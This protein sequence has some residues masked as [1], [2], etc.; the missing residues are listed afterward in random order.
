MRVNT[1]KA[2]ITV[3]DNNDK[4]Q[5]ITT[6]PVLE[7][8]K[9]VT[10]EETEITNRALKD[11]LTL[12]ILHFPSTKRR[13]LEKYLE[14]GSKAS[15][16]AKT[17]VHRDT[18]YDW[19]GTD[20][21]FALAVAEAD[22]IIL[23]RLEETQVRCAFDPKYFMD[24]AMQ[25]RMRDAKYTQTLTHKGDRQHPIQIEKTIIVMSGEQGDQGQIVDGE[26]KEIEG[27]D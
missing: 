3:K 23:D 1:N 18:I 26:V 11:S 25:L 22:K 14:Y 13:W 19:L 9:L 8:E 21:E 27:G 10:P 4:P 20:K 6:S 16:A 5:I 7:P 17:G 15:A 12:H 24:R 2:Y